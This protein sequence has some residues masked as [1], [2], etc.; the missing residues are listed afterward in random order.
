VNIN[1]F[2]QAELLLIALFNI[3]L[4]LEW[5]IIDLS[6]FILKVTSDH[7]TGDHNLHV[8]INAEGWDTGCEIMVE[9]QTPGCGYQ[10]ISGTGNLAWR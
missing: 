10:K 4:L 5:F 8:L 7:Q 2:N 1:I 3:N 6:T 9:R